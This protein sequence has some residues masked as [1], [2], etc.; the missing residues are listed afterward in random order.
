MGL[1]IVKGLLG[2]SIVKALEFVWGF[3][4]CV[5]LTT[6]CL[7]YDKRA[8]VVCNPTRQGQGFAFVIVVTKSQDALVW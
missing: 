5:G 6:I 8:L 1:A 3:G 2:L 7:W 4:V